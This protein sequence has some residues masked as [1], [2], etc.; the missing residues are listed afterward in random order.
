MDY[1]VR[2]GKPGAR[3]LRFG[4]RSIRGQYYHVITCTADRRAFFADLNCGREVVQSIKRLENERITRSMA[5]VVM[6]DHVHWLMQL[7]Q[8]KGLSACVASMKSFAARN[9]NAKGFAQGPI[10][11][12]GYMDRAIRHEDQ[13]VWVARYIVANP[14]RAGIVEH[15]GDYP[16]WDS[17][18]M[19]DPGPG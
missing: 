5:F 15:I 1:V 4:R 17:V 19:D 7:G 12:K 16:L 14:L 3:S 8:R 9:I 13:L 11:Q 6:P 10:W 18:W 2:T